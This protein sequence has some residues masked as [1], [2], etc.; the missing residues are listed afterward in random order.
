[1]AGPEILNPFLG[2]WNTIHMVIIILDF[3]GIAAFIYLSIKVF[4]F[5]PNFVKHPHGLSSEKKHA[6]QS[7]KINNDWV[8]VLKIF[9]T[10]TPESL[11]LSVITADSLVDGV[12][13][14]MGLMGETFADRMTGLNK[15]EL[16]SLDDVWDSH[17]LRNELVHTPN[18]SLSLN[19]AKKALRG[20][21]SF[22]RELGVLD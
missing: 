17:R 21:R 9:K 19:E 1:M 11:K 14:K 20:Y 22:L 5:R 10:G 6:Y 13:Q 15:Q 18:K 3:L 4:A 2:V 16:K 7:L 12:L 8:K